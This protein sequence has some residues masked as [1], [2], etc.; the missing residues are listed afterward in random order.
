MYVKYS[1]NLRTI[2]KYMPIVT[3]KI[4]LRIDREGVSDEDYKNLWSFLR[5]IDDNLYL[6]ANR[7]SSHWFLN[8]EYANRLRAQMPKYREIV[9]K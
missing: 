4:E 2:K 1:L 9:K 8:D 3:R 7:I 5:Q 6:A